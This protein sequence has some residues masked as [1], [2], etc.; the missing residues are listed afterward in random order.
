ML[1]LKLSEI[2]LDEAHDSVE[3]ALINGDDIKIT[4]ETAIREYSNNQII[5]SEKSEDYKSL[6]ENTSNVAK[7]TDDGKILA[8]ILMEKFDSNK[9]IDLMSSLYENSPQMYFDIMNIIVAILNA[10]QE[11]AMNKFLDDVTNINIGNVKDD[12]ADDAVEVMSDEVEEDK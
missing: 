11:S 1:F 12:E 5:E 2:K 7:W 10:Y 3:E 6:F 9:M 8:Q 4:L